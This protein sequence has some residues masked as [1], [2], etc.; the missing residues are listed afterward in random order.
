MILML[1]GSWIRDGWSQE[2]EHYFMTVSTLVARPLGMGGAFTSVEDDLTAL[3]YNPA[4]FALYQDYPARA[5]RLSVFLNP[6]APIVAL[7][8]PEAL[9]GRSRVTWEEAAAALGM[10]VK[11]VA[12]SRGVFEL[13]AVFG[14]QAPQ[15]ELFSKTRFFNAE[16][17]LDN[18]YNVLAVR[19]RVAERVALGGSL[20]LYYHHSK[21]YGRKW[22][23][24]TSYGVRVR[25]ARHVAVG[26]SYITFPQMQPGYRE[27]LERIVDGTVN[28]GVSV[29]SSFGTTVAADIRNLGD[30]KAATGELIREA[31]FGVEQV[32]LSHLALRIGLFRKRHEDAE[33]R[34]ALSAGFGLVEGNRF[35]PPRRRFSHPS[36]VMNYGMVTEMVADHR[37]FVH[38]LAL[39]VRL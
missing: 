5:G 30:E 8:Q 3:L 22:G 33:D 7:Q 27:A 10:L 13:G 25:P 26:I 28:L 16:G 39:M 14:E 31:H 17:Y 29:R 32:L 38:A 24:G 35:W 6:I 37:R 34:Y 18:Q 15:P 19:M 1:W 20:G 2:H 4:S 21:Q 23:M 12:L 36:W 9:F 11:G